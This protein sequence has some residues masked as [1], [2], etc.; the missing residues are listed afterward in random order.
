MFYDLSVIKLAGWT[1]NGPFA[2]QSISSNIDPYSRS[3]NWKCW[4]TT[5]VD[6][7]KSLKIWITMTLLSLS[8]DSASAFPNGAV[9]P[10]LLSCSSCLSETR[11]VKSQLA[12][13]WARKH[14]SRRLASRRGTAETDLPIHQK[15]GHQAPLI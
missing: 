6:Y 11:S 10:L 5:Q 9:R 3:L 2:S 7:M 12:P 8:L 15:G 13:V 14:V 1:R 4:A